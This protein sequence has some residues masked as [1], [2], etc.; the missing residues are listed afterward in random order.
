VSRSAPEALTPAM[1]VS[2]SAL[3]F[4]ATCSACQGIDLRIVGPPLTE[5]AKLYGSNPG[6]IVVWARAPGKKREGFPQMPAFA[7]LGESKLGAIAKYM[8]EAGSGRLSTP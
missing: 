7:S 1:P 3:L 4:E 2:A 5:I 6:G 8:I